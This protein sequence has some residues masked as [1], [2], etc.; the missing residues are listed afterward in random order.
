[1]WFGFVVWVLF[2]ERGL[3]VFYFYCFSAWFCSVFRWSCVRKLRFSREGVS[4]R[5]FRRLAVGFCFRV[6]W[7]DF[8]IGCFFVIGVFFSM[9]FEKKFRM[10]LVYFRFRVILGFFE[11]FF[12]W[13]SGF[14]YFWCK[15]YVCLGT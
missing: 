10:F 3:F 6:W 4:S 13:K 2:V 5:L 12:K 7:F 1:M 15:N 14:V 8:D 11:S 9:E